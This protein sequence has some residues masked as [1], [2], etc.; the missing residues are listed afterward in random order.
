MPVANRSPVNGDTTM[1]KFD[2]FDA[3]ADGR[4]ACASTKSSF[5]AVALLGD[6]GEPASCV[7]RPTCGTPPTSTT[8]PSL[9]T[10][11]PGGASRLP[12][13]SAESARNVYVCPDCPS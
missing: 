6:G 12:A 4:F 10:S 1:V 2:G 13:L 7:V 11:L 9:G 8:V 5:V 3:T